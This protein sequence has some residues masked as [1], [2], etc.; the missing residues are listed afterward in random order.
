MRP[1]QDPHAIIGRAPS[2]AKH[3]RSEIRNKSGNTLETLSEQILNLQVSYS[4]RSPNPGKQSRFP[5]QIN[6]RT[7]LPPVRLGPF[8]FLKGPL[9]GTARAG[10]EIPNSTG[11]T[12]EISSESNLYWAVL[13]EIR[14]PC[15]LSTKYSSTTFTLYGNAWG[16]LFQRTFLATKP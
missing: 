15:N 3:F 6:F 2:A 10:H 5:S 16:G 8:P 9:H 13:L 11:G 1:F 4:W 14:N 12:S 7:A